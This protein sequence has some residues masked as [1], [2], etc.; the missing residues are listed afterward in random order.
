MIEIHLTPPLL[1]NYPGCIDLTDRRF[2]WYLV[3][4]YAGR[5]YWLVKCDCD[6][7]RT[8]RGKDL[9][10]GRVKSCGCR[11]V[12]LNRQRTR[13][14][15]S[16]SAI[17]NIWSH[18]R[19]RCQDSKNLAYKDYGGRGIKVC[20]RWQVF[21]NFY[22][23]MGE[24]PSLEHSLDRIDNDGNYEPENCRWA[25]HQEQ[26]NNQRSNRNIT[27]QGKTQTISAW[28]RELGIKP[29]A[30]FSR[31]KCGFSVE[32]ALRPVRYASCISVPQEGT[33]KRRA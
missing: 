19:R 10:R 12:A 15:K 6:V 21:D 9:R 27:F 33:V 4:A 18:M 24:R 11:R 20:D 32:E 16:R 14:G 25:T 30:L 26:A 22:A 5:E 1:R 13:H 23:D 28:A 17:Y 7:L 29:A 8:V 31:F 3:L 2:G